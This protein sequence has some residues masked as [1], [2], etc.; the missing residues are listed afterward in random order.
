MRVGDGT[1]GPGRPAGVPNKVNASVKAAV[2][3]A[4]ERR[5]GVDA[6]LRWAEQNP[7]AFYTAMVGKLIPK[8]IEGTGDGGELVITLVRRSVAVPGAG[9]PASHPDTERTP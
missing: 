3:E 4:F 8:A 9:P 2:Q 7:D 5:G 1:P 6:L